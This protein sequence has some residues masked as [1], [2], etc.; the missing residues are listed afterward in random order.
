M[1]V[2]IMHYTG[3]SRTY[4]AATVVSPNSTALPAVVRSF[5]LLWAPLR[6]RSYR[7]LAI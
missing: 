2:I 5:C 6:R 7:S 4:R 3:P 1:G